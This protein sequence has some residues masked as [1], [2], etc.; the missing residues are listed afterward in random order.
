MKLEALYERD[1]MRSVDP[2]AK[3]DHRDA[4]VIQ[5]EIEEYFFTDAL[6]ENFHGFLSRFVGGTEETTGF[7]INGFYGSGKSHFLKYLFYLLSDEHGDTAFQHLIESLKRKEA[8]LDDK[9]KV[10][11]ATRYRDTVRDLQIAPVMFNISAFAKKSEDDE[12]TVTETFFN[13][14]NHF[15]G[16]HKSDLRIARFEKQLD[17]DGALEA[18]KQ[19]FQEKTGEVWEEEALMAVDFYVDAV[20]DVAVSVSSFDK[21]STRNTLL[22]DVEVST[23]EFVDEVENYLDEQPDTFRLVFLVD[24]VSQFMSGNENMLLDLQTIVE[25]IGTRCKDKVWVAC[26]AQQELKELLDTTQVNSI[27]DSFGKI[28]ARFEQLPL[29][30]QEAHR[31]AKKRILEKS[32][33]DEGGQVNAKRY[34]SN[35]FAENETALRNQFER[36]NDVYRGIQSEE[37]FVECY[38]FVPYQFTL[39]TD[40]IQSFV[41]ESF[42][43]PGVSGT[44]R[45]LIGIT[46]ETA[47]ACKDEEVGYVVP[48]DAFFN[49]Q[50]RDNL[51]NVARNVI[52]RA[53]KL[54]KVQKKPFWQRVVRALFLLAY[55]SDTKA[56][57]FPSTVENIAFVLM[58]E[59]D[60]GKTQLQHE[61]QKALDYLVDNNVVSVD[62]SSYR[63][64]MEEE[65]RVKNNIDEFNI[66]PGDRLEFLDR[67]IVGPLLDWSKSYSLDGT[68]INLKRQIDR[69]EI[70][71]SGT[72]PVQILVTQGGDADQFALDRAKKDLV[73]CIHE[74]FEKEQRV[75]LD[76]AVKVDAF[77]RAN[78]DRAEGKRREAIQMFADQAKE[79][80]NELRNWF[81]EALK[82]GRYVS[83]QQVND[84]SDHAGGKAK[85]RYTAILDAHVRDVYSKRDMATDYASNRSKLAQVANDP[86]REFGAS[87]QPAEQEVHNHLR[88]S[89]AP[90]ATDTINHFAGIPYGWQDTE[91]IHILLNLERSNKWTFQYNSEDVP[92]GTFVEKAVNRSSRASITF[93]QQEEIDPTLLY[94]VTEAIN[95]S[96]FTDTKV[97]QETDPKRLDAQITKVF[98]EKRTRYADKARMESSMP[99]ATHLEAARDAFA[100]LLEFKKKPERFEA[101]V[102][103]AEEIGELVDTAERTMEFVETHGD[104]YHAIRDFVSRRASDFDQL[105][106]SDR[107]VAKKLKDYVRS[108]EEPYGRV[109]R[110]M[111][112]YYSNVQDALNAKVESLREDVIKRYEE[113]FGE[114]EE[115]QDDLNV[116]GVLPA[117]ASRIDRVKRYSDPYQLDAETSRVGEF[118][119]EYRKKIRDQHEAQKAPPPPPTSSSGSNEGGDGSSA[120]SGDGGESGDDSKSPPAEP[121]TS[122][123]FSVDTEMPAK[124]LETKEDVDAFVESLRDRLYERI[125]DDKIILVGS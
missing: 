81:A 46:H 39:I 20:V 113:A 101:I 52:S 30:A 62:G 53:M 69:K 93:R 9:M 4:D 21:E 119:T 18:F 100:D 33:S 73:F 67:N 102:E 2:V 94:Q 98:E 108:E 90:N 29:E 75:K 1:I 26:T 5:Q 55:L 63:F 76:E 84:A 114:L 17:R 50:I 71:P 88:N 43:V 32:K 19:A 116:E 85:E 68:K 121:K 14:F 64:L 34:L 96:M 77:K 42:L 105:E 23:D 104:D 106:P 86:Q 15:R 123:S 22:R 80:I 87:L 92:R 31:I 109:F 97:H 111:S 8:S 89:A 103:R 91:V 59:V 118:K 25:Q 117:R 95:Q 124:D 99:Y 70:D 125:D 74:A 65:I 38:P 44:E 35:Y 45:S 82:N 37:E 56:K 57:N 47:K 78:Y 61:T 112:T 16:Y 49:K 122:E 58:D 83:A 54:E 24:E 110:E 7:W 48:F 36:G 28:I 72:I 79:T 115:Y 120:T 51:K 27:R 11:D 66:K 107:E 3:V 41:Q 40:V 60:Q 10:P 6:F 12:T 13:R